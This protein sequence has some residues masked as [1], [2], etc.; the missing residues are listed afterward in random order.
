M[1]MRDDFGTTELIELTNVIYAATAAGLSHADIHK[2]ATAWLDENFNTK[3][4]RQAEMG[5]R[6]VLWNCARVDKNRR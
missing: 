4:P 6:G 1:A 3:T 2:A 5:M